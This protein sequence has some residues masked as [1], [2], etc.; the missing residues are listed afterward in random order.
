VA[1]TAWKQL[2]RR[3][4]RALG[5][6]RR[7]PTGVAVSDCIDTPFAVSVKRSKRRV[8]EGR[9]IDGAVEFGRKE[10]KPWLLVVAGH[11]DREPLAVLS[12]PQLVQ[13]LREARWI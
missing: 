13:I 8:P 5:G 1:D 2:E 12:F 11:S 10:E 3:V 7:G 9:M 4:C 6:D